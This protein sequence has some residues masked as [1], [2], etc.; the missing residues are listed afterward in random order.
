MHFKLYSRDTMP[1]KKHC[2]CFTYSHDTIHL[3]VLSMLIYALV[4]ASL[5]A[6]YPPVWLNVYFTVRQAALC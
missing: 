4:T 5:D 1:L 3:K 2:L 6:A